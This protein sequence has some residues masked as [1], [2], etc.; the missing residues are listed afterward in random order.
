MCFVSLC[1]SY[2]FAPLTLHLVAAPHPL[3]LAT[4]GPVV[5]AVALNVVI[6]EVPV[7]NAAI[8]PS[9]LTMPMLSTL[10]VL[11]LVRCS[12]WPAFFS[13]SML[14]ILFPIT[15]VT[16]PVQ[17]VVG[18][19][20]ISLI[21]FPFADIAISIGMNEPALSIGLI[22]KPVAF[23]AAS[24][25]PNLRSF[26]RSRL[27]AFYPLA[28][29]GCFV[30]KYGL[31]SCLEAHAC[32]LA[33]KLR[34]VIIESTETFPFCF[35]LR[36]FKELDRLFNGN[37]RVQLGKLKSFDGL[38]FQLF[39]LF[40]LLGHEHLQDAPVWLQIERDLFLRLRFILVDFP[41]AC[42]VGKVSDGRGYGNTHAHANIQ[43]DFVFIFHDEL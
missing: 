35:N 9:E 25:R 8:G 29:V 3:V 42:P 38:I 14:L 23:V 13:G 7:E 18:S 21:I 43:H 33:I 30:V 32:M 39:Q 11:A 1:V 36:I 16:R 41:L 28:S 19:I 27:C 17:V 6:E 24:V 22:V 31:L 2:L 20:A 12:V 10:D 40:C 5:H 37:K 15:H 4:I 26:S 34:V